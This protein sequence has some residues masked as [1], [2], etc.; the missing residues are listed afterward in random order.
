M[1]VVGV[2]RG[3]WFVSAGLAA[4]LVAGCASAPKPAKISGT[5]EASAS[6]NPSA[7]QR[8]SPVMLRVYELKSPTAF[9]AADFM[10]LY[11]RDQ[12]ELASDFVAREEMTLAPG[13]SRPLTKTLSVDTKYIGVVAAFRDLEHARWRAIAPVQPGKAHKVVIRADALAVTVTVSR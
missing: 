2:T 12:A 5:I 4:M 6:V 1:T 7:S 10:S 8:P 9:N 13:E 3:W 11:Q